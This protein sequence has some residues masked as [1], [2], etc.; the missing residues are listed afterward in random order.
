MAKFISRISNFLVSGFAYCHLPLSGIHCIVTYVIR[1]ISF[2]KLFRWWGSWYWLSIPGLGLGSSEKKRRRENCLPFFGPLK[3]FASK[4]YKNE[5]IWVTQTS[6]FEIREKIVVKFSKLIF[7]NCL[8]YFQKCAKT[9]IFCWSQ[10]LL[11]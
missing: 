11:F 6:N 2:H 1:K 9:Q 7:V 3:R 8:W 5:S 10:L 4:P